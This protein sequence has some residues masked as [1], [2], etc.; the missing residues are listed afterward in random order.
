MAHTKHFINAYSLYI[1]KCCGSH[2]FIVIPIF[3]FLL[4]YSS[5][6]ILICFLC[7]SC[8]SICSFLLYITDSHFL[9]TNR[10]VSH[11]YC[12][13]LLRQAS[14]NQE[15]QSLNL[16]YFH[17]FVLVLIQRYDNNKLL[18]LTT[19]IQEKKTSKTNS[20]NVNRKAI[21]KTKVEN[22][23]ILG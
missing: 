22:K 13:Y 18:Y 4:L 7:C 15:N 16:I 1:N 17:S 19:Y 8:S 11:A 12:N 10:V 21:T 23:S 3:R 20:S 6:N 2:D 5:H 14:L 9:R